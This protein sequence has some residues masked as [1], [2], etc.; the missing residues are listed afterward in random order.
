MNIITEILTTLSTVVI[1]WYS[2][3]SYRLSKEIKR[4]NDLREKSEEEFK[5]QI[6]DLYQAIVVATLISGPSSVGAVTQTG[7]DSVKNT[8]NQYYKGS[9]QIFPEKK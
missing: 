1:A 8:F 9:T 2:F 6:S 3:Q 5:R 4:V 7:I